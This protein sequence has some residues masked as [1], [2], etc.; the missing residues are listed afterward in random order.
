MII[1][2]KFINI[3]YTIYTHVPLV[4]IK[5]YC[6]ILSLYSG[7]SQLVLS[8]VTLAKTKIELILFV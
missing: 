7:R 6:I 2:L 8:D 5:I 3:N 4:Y 1:L